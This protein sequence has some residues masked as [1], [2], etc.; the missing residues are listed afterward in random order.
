MGQPGICGNRNTSHSAT[1]HH[2][3]R[4]EDSNK[5]K[6]EIKLPV[7][8]QQK[9]KNDLKEENIP[10]P[11]RPDPHSTQKQQEKKNL[12]KKN[13]FHGQLYVDLFEAY[14]KDGNGT[15]DLEEAKLIFEDFVDGIGFWW[16][17]LFPLLVKNHV[18]LQTSEDDCEDAQ[19][20]AYMEDEMQTCEQDIER[21]KE[22]LRG[23]G[24]KVFMAHVDTDHDGVIEKEEWEA[25]VM[26]ALEIL[27]PRVIRDGKSPHEHLKLQME[28][29]RRLARDE[30]DM[31]T[32]FGPALKS[33]SNKL[34]GKS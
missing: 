2:H 22:H 28:A 13:S 31:K 3:S 29:L 30:P 32:E 7:P 8:P 15:L 24:A 18:I 25:F 1:H 6:E 5:E 11:P 21:M 33:M 20:E 14:D 4:S 16:S 19:I 12:E 10:R 23:P 17:N 34:K 26:Q 9:T 27:A